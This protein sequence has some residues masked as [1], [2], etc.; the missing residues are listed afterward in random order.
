MVTKGS[1]RVC[2]GARNRGQQYRGWDLWGMTEIYNASRVHGSSWIGGS[3]GRGHVP[4]AFDRSRSSFRRWATRP[5][6]A[7]AP[8]ITSAD[9]QMRPRPNA[10]RIRVGWNA[11]EGPACQDV[12]LNRNRLRLNRSSARPPLFVPSFRAYLERGIRSR[13]ISVILSVRTPS[14]IKIRLWS[15]K[16]VWLNKKYLKNCVFYL[17]FNKEG[18]LSKMFPWF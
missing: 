4:L 2:A 9:R 1:A 7:P 13:T 5:S 17:I 12:P 16:R 14:S 6:S 11:W 3:V 15:G 10:S 18:K 8:T